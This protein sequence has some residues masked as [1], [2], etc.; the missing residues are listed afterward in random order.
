[1]RSIRNY[2]HTFFLECPLVRHECPNYTSGSFG[3]VYPGS[4]LGGGSF[5]IGKLIVFM[6]HCAI[7]D[8]PVPGLYGMNLCEQILIKVLSLLK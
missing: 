7:N 6:G 4:T 2:F 8:D 3:R 5:V 1:M